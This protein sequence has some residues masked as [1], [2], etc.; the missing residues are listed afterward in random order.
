MGFLSSRLFVRSL[1]ILAIIIVAGVYI[2]K[3]S[4]NAQIA[5]CR[6]FKE[7]P[8]KAFD[9]CSDLLQKSNLTSETLAVLYLNRGRA[10]FELDDPQEAL[11]NFDAAI[12][13]VDTDYFIWQWKSAAHDTL[14]DYPAT[15]AAI[16]QSLI[17]RPSSQ[18]SL[19]RRLELLQTLERYDEAREGYNA[20]MEQYPEEIWIPRAFGKFQV[21]QEDYPSAAISYKAA[22]QIDL[23]DEDSRKGFYEACVYAKDAC[24]DL[25]PES[26]QGRTSLTCDQATARVIEI[27]SDPKDTEREGRGARVSARDVIED[28]A[29]GWV[30]A[31]SIY[32][33]SAVAF[34]G[35]GSEE[36]AQ[37][38]ILY[39]RVM[40]CTEEGYVNG[41]LFNQGTYDK[42]NEFYGARVRENLLD[43][44][45]LT[46]EKM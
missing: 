9:A 24:P 20:L 28:P 23:D 35:D 12:S 25:F 43:I 8:Q 7:N 30:M 38:I 4:D 40:G 31:S 33:G 17:L 44:A 18:F 36:K 27:L 14:E 42:F 41:A 21:S 26:R 16:E 45:H 29:K 11:E 3:Q 6:A 32:L 19:R 1:A 22:L 39:D 5:A 37:N 15:L 34:I 10:L 13:H 46:L 2:K